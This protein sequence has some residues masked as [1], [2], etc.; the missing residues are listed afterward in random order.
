M[1]N[2]ADIIFDYS[3]E[4]QHVPGYKNVTPDILSRIYEGK[5]WG[6]E[7]ALR[8]TDVKI[9][10]TQT[11]SEETPTLSES[12]TVGAPNSLK[13]L[14][15]ACGKVIPAETERRD[16]MKDAHELGHFGGEAM[17]KRIFYDDKWW[18]SMLADCKQFVSECR[19]CQFYS[20]TRRGYHPLRS[21]QASLPFDQLG[22]DLI[23]MPE[24][25]H[26]HT[27]V[28]VVIDKLTKFVILRPLKNKSM[29]T[30]APEMWKIFADFGIPKIV[31]SDNGKE[32]VNELFLKLV[33]KYGIE[34]R[35]VSEY[36]PKANGLAERVNNTVIISLK[37]HLM[38]NTS[39]WALHLPYIQLCYN[40]Q[41][42]SVTGSTPYSLM[43]ARELSQF[44]NYENATDLGKMEKSPSRIN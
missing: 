41:I 30:V 37:K 9:Q 16:L 39:D 5:C 24:D 38:G 28:L 42:S 31:Q 4:I 20:V 23:I 15:Q 19:P 43:F 33:E 8:Q 2:W 36:N 3:F 32:F 18:P 10:V 25:Q 12:R 40:S 27:A 44:Q 34:H 22:I 14:M 13:A 17:M 6:E 21:Q 7:S 26:G 29:A 11:K 1:N 35:L